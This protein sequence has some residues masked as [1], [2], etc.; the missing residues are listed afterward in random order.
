VDADTRKRGRVKSAGEKASIAGTVQALEAWGWTVET[1]V[2][3]AYNDGPHQVDVV[4]KRLGHTLVL[5]IK[6][7]GIL[8]GSADQK[9][10]WDAERLAQLVDP[11]VSAMI[12]VWGPHWDAL[13]EGSSTVAEC[14]RL[15]ASHGV[16]VQVVRD[17]EF[18]D[19]ERTLRSRL[20]VAA[21]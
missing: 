21:A 2:Q 20:R 13:M 17:A 18:R 3:F 1:D 8:D 16:P 6:W 11:D 7:Q 10:L 5:E 15:L 14:R 12:V 9:I 4:A 19:A